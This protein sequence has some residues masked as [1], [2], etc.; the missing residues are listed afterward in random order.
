MF[1]LDPR[2]ENDTMVVGDLPLCRV[3]LMNDSQFPW[4][5]LVPRIENAVEVCQ[6][7]AQDRL[8]LWEESHLISESMMSLFSPDKLNVAALG[9]VVKQLHIHHVA[10]FTNDIAWPHPIW[11]KLPAVNY[12]VEHAANRLKQLRTKLNMEK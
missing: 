2:L 10:R 9:N 6:L 3:L 7:E 4:L 8:R 1:K 5:I 12:S 11:G